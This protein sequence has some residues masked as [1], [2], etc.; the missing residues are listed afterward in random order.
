M[1]APALLP[2]SKTE[3]FMTNKWWSL[4]VRPFF[5]RKIPNAIAGVGEINQ[6][7]STT[8]VSQLM[9]TESGDFSKSSVIF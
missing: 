6:G 3:Y 1:I 8:Y 7:A 4:V 2:L 9:V 5:V